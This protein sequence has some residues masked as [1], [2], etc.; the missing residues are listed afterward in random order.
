MTE[1]TTSESFSIIRGGLMERAL[2]LLHVIIPSGNKNTLRKIIFFISITWIPLLILTLVSGLFWTESIQMNF[3]ED[4]PVHLRFLVAVPMLLIAEIIVDRRVKLV[5][6]HFSESGLVTEEGKKEFELAKLKTDRLCEMPWAEAVF[7]LIIIGNI[8]FR[9]VIHDIVIS[10]WQIPD[11]SAQHLSLAGY[12]LFIVSM[13]LFQFMIL[14]WLWRW[15]IWFRL[16]HL[17]SKIRLYLLPTHPDK[18]GG[19]GFLGEPP[20]P[21]SMITMAFGIVVSAFIAGRMVFFNASL[22]DFYGAIAGFVFICILINIIPLLV[23]F[24]ALRK[25]RISGIF[26]YSALVDRHH[27]EF[28]EKWF[29][30]NP[31]KELLIGNADISSMCDFTPVYEAIEGMKPFPFNLKIMLSTIL[32]SIMPLLPL[33]ALEMPVGDILKALVGFLL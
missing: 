18:S 32:V 30:L 25:V 2:E 9:W 12:W 15:A 16:L 21:F 14:R 5:V 19:L 29:G 10:T 6:N 3:F 1:Y 11:A 20:V 23:F 26:E 31:D 24:S 28:T 22:S 8:T 13:P 33:L 4:F 7:L 27:R 17:I